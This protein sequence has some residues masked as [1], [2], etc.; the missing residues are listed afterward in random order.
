MIV[1]NEKEKLLKKIEELK[2][3]VEKLNNNYPKYMLATNKFKSRLF[4]V[5]FTN[6][7]EGTVIATA[8]N[9]EYPI[10]H[11]SKHWFDCSNKNKWKEVNNP[12]ELCDKD[13][14]ECWDNAH[15]YTRRISFYDAK[16]TCLFS[17][18]GTRDGA[19][20]DNYRK[21]M[22]WEYPDWAIEA[23]KSLKN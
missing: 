13:L 15:P 12:N 20:Y 14:V 1:C 4:I 7:Y 9:S 23:Q 10:Q 16:N 11:N 17:I 21:L 18:D 19:I 22:P 6:M 2:Q 5:E 3:Q 8:E